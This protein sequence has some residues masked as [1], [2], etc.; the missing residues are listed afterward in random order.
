[1]PAIRPPPPTGTST[2]SIASS[3]RS[4]S[5]ATVPWP[6]ITSG[7]LYGEMYTRPLSPAW[8]RAMVSTRP[9][10]AS[11]RRRSAPRL[12]SDSSLSGAERR[13]ELQ[14]RCPDEGPDPP[15]RQR[16][17]AHDVVTGELD[18]GHWPLLRRVRNCRCAPRD[19]SRGN[20]QNCRPPDEPTPAPAC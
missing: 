15:F 8:A 7:S 12:L 11:T 14:R 5:I 20:L 9:G 6:P 2:E 1:M 4:S 16:H 3:S 13:G 10:S 19:D 17:L 18:C